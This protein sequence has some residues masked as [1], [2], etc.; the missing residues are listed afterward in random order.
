MKVKVKRNRSVKPLPAAPKRNDT[1]ENQVNDMIT[2]ED[3]VEQ[4]I[5][6]MAAPSCC[7][8]REQAANM[9]GMLG[10]N[11]IDDDIYHTEDE[12]PGMIPAM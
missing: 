9:L 1:D 12:H 3:L 5:Y 8:D 2:A 6:A 4:A 7:S 10:A 11:I